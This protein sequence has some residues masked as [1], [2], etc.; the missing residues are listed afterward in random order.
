VF[1]NNKTFTYFECE[2]CKSAVIDP[3]PNEEDF[4]KMYG[5]NDHRYLSKLKP[6]EKLTFNFVSE[7]YNHQGYQLKFFD[8]H[9]Y[10]AHAKTLL[11]IGCGSGFYMKYA[12]EKGLQCCGI[13]FDNAFVKL[14]KSKTDLTLFTFDQFEKEKKGEKFDLIHIGHMLEHSTDPDNVINFARKF[15]HKDTVLIVDGPLEKNKCLSRWFI[16]SASLLKNKKYNTYPPQHLSFT[17]Y[18]S[19]IL[20]FERNG[21][22]TQN[23]EVTEQMF[24]LPSTFSFKNPFRTALFCL[25]RLSVNISKLHY[26]LGNVFHYAGKFKKLT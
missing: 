25:A 10:A 13:E 12:A 16:K 20:F 19:Q 2:D 18:D 24:P 22:L 5:E 15:A 7:P 17:N 1:F 14:L 21:L 6:D 26:R 9:N 4:S 11:D 8:S 3:L 23:Y